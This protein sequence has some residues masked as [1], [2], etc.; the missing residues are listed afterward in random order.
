[1]FTPLILKKLKIGVKV[2]KAIGK[3]FMIVF[4]PYE[5]PLYTLYG[6]G[7]GGILRFEGVYR[8]A[9]M[10]P[11]GNIGGSGKNKYLYI[12]PQHASC[13]MNSLR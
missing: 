4:S 7:L 12:I 11:K 2:M 6:L 3:V 1:M 13:Y 10:L 5:C 9:S 8:G